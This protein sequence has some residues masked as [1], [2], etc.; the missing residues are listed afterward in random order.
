MGE[1]RFEIVGTVDNVTYENAGAYFLGTDIR[2]KLSSMD[3]LNMV[4]DFLAGV[5]DEYHPVINIV[6]RE[7]SVLESGGR[8][9]FVYQ[10]IQTCRLGPT[11]VAE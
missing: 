11:G 1:R 7:E 3:A 8:R 4:R 5:T 9:L 10:L 6:L 2:T